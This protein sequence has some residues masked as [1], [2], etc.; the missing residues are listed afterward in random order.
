MSEAER[1][2]PQGRLIL[3]LTQ[4]TDPYALRKA[5][6]LLEHEAGAEA[7][8]RFS[9][10]ELRFW[11]FVHRGTPVTLQWE[12]DAGLSLVAGAAE[13]GVETTTRDLALVLRTKLDAAGLVS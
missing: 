11:D 1:R 8:D 9:S 7:K 2:D 6:E 5:G 10:A 3:P 12:R 13:D 4:N